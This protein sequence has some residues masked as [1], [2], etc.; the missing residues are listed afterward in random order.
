MIQPSIEIRSAT[1]D[2]I[3]RVVS[4]IVAAF[5]TDPP[6]RFAWPSPHDY[7]LAMPV[8]TGEFAGSSFQHGTAYVSA[9]FRGAALWLPPGVEPN[10]RALEKVFRDTAK[11]E[12]MDDLLATFEKMEQS[13]PREPHWYLPQIGVEPNAQGKGI[14]AALMRHALARCDHEGSLAYLEAS[15]P[16]NIPFYRHHGFEVTGEIQMGSAPLVTPM[17]RKRRRP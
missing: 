3:P 9:D 1:S 6:A 5:L 14:G 11:P 8:A 12:H 16:Q 4:T 10:G 17:L 2:E 7:L 13:H 15:K